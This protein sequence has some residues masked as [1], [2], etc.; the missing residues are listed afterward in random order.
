MKL[1]LNRLARN[2]SIKAGANIGLRGIAWTHSYWGDGDALEK[3]RK[4]M[5]AWAF[6]CEPKTLGQCGNHSKQT[7]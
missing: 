4:L 3:R 2:G 6:Y 5:D 7:L 1:D